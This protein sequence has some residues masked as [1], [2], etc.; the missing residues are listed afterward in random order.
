MPSEMNL[1]SCLWKSKN[2]ELFQLIQGTSPL[3]KITKLH[4]HVMPWINELPVSS[5]S[6]YHSGIPRTKTNLI[7]GDFG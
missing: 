5:V 6:I 4:V 1:E 2:N 3:T 7:R